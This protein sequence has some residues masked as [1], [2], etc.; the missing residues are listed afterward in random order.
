MRVEMVYFANLD[1]GW[2]AILRCDLLNEKFVQLLKLLELE[3]ALHIYARIG[4]PLGKG[5]TIHCASA[6]SSF[7]S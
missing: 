3:V 7:S 2:G 4:E 5:A 6:R 1:C